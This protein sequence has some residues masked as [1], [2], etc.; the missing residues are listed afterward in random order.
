MP[1][2]RQFKTQGPP[3]N[4]GI[5]SNMPAF[6]QEVP[7]SCPK[8][9]CDWSVCSQLIPKRY[10]QIFLKN[11]LSY[12]IY[13]SIY[14]SIYLSILLSI[15]LSIYPFIYYLTLIPCIFPLPDNGSET[16]LH[17]GSHLQQITVVVMFTF[18]RDDCVQWEDEL[19]ETD[20]RTSALFCRKLK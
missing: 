9:N 12:I 14:L 2:S 8:R 1:K 4:Q 17:F 16:I 6:F 10:I 20:E 5:F 18:V 7:I 3:V 19:G 11:D 15:Y 13:S